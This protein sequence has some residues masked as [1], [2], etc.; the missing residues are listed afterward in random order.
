M[1]DPWSI[2]SDLGAGGV[3][4]GLT[5]ALKA[6]G[7]LAGAGLAALA[8]RRRS[9][10]TRHLVW[11][12]GLAGALAVLPLA[13]AMPD[14]GVPLLDPP[15][16]SGSGTISAPEPAARPARLVQEAVVAVPVVPQTTSSATT[17]VLSV[18]SRVAGASRLSFSWPLLTWLAG[19]LAVLAWGAAGYA[20]TWR[21]ERHAERVTDSSWA[22][23]LCE[24]A[25]RLRT[26]R[27]V[28]LL[29][30]GR[31]LMPLTW[32]V[33]RPVLLLPEEAD[34]W[35]QER[36][37]AVL[38]HELAHVRRRDCLTQWL[39]LAACAAYWFNPLAW[40][41]ASR[42]RT[43]REQACDDLVLQA[44]ERASDYA[45]QLLDVARSLRPAPTLA[46]A[47][48][49]MARISGLEIRLRAILDAP[50]PAR[51]F[52]LAGVH[53]PGGRARS[54][55][56]ARRGTPGGAGDAPPGGQRP[57]PGTGRQAARGG[58]GRRGRG[59]LPLGVQSV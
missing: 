19:T 27:H 25:E 41:A 9:A 44:G 23:A 49:A 53:V 35:P 21:L 59:P 47:G 36:R 14:W 6:T 22:S 4:T 28:I 24:A 3:M 29:R 57:G 1:D 16:R 43:E 7:V 26:R 2:L 58:R 30:G 33:M 20:S 55:G 54:L 56:S 50:E 15:G 46:P 5:C 42:L 31:A 48:L 12:L 32:G 38:L 17:E 11:C 34:E 10:A 51:P 40:W 37:R 45:A 8:M 13:L 18:P 39:G 52:A